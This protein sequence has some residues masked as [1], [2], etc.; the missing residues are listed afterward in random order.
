MGTRQLVVCIAM[1]LVVGT[2]AMARGAFVDGV[3]IN[4]RVFN[5]FPN[6][7]LVTTNNYSALVEFDESDYG[8]GG[9]AN[10]HDALLSDDA[11]ATAKLFSIDDPFVVK[12]QVTLDVGATSPRKEAGIR[13]N[14]PVTGDVLFL[15][16]SDA[17]EIVAFGG[18][19]PF[20]LFG[21]NGNGNGYTPGDMILMQMTYQPSGGGANGVPGTVVYRVDRGNGWESSG[22]LPWANLE[23]GPVN[24]NVGFYGQAS[25]DQNDPA[26]YMIARFENIMAMEVPEPAS[27]I[28]AAIAA[29]GGCVLLRRRG[30]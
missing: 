13:I 2:T 29:A 15:V 11:G 5:D 26:D 10:R 17:G 25:P 1:A 20:H 22:P 16:N 6:S 23:G 9:F 21:S 30:N 8:A 14:S 7:T 19:G 4:E 27:M 3:K 24:F 12:A 18:G 28:L